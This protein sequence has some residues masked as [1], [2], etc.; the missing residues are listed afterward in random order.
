MPFALPVTILRINRAASATLLTI[1]VVRSAPV[2]CQAAAIAVPSAK[3]AVGPFDVRIVQRAAALLSSPGHWNRVDRGGCPR[4]DTTYTVRCALGR[5]IKE[6]AGLEWNPAAAGAPANTKSSPRPIECALHVSADDPGGSCGTLWEE[7]PVFFVSRAKTISSGVWRKDAQ[8][9]EVWAGTMADAEGPVNFEGR[10]G[11]DVVA[12]R[13]GSDPLIEFNNDST[14]TFADVREYF[15]ELEARVQQHAA[16]DMERVADSVEIEIYK[17]GHGVIRTYNGWFPVSG[18]T[19]H[20]SRITFRMDTTKEIAPNAV[21]RQILVR[22]MKILSSDSVWNRADDR[23]CP[24]H[25]TKWSIYCAVEQ[26]EIDVAGGYH[27][28]RPAG[29]LVREIVDERTKSRN[30]HHRMM[31]YNND[32]TTTLADVQSLFAEAIARIRP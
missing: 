29:E 23:T 32:P 19:A 3:T 28:R 10:H 14:T 8:P 16:S 25:A 7:V 6:A 12:R 18:F 27:H 22:A 11:V 24:A 15:R 5:A 4:E 9:T 13:K 17:G 26:A 2:L 20:G 30:Y 21:D 1:A 31:D